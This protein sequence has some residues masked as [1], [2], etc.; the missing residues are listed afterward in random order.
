MITC[1]ALSSIES[2]FAHVQMKVDHC[3]GHHSVW[4]SRLSAA[5]YSPEPSGL[6]LA[7]LWLISSVVVSLHSMKPICNDMLPVAKFDMYLW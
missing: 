5:C 2:V 3:M 6:L 7:K 4:T 1:E